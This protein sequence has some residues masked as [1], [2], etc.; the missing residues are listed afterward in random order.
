MIVWID[1]ANGVG[2]SH[3]ATE[4]AETLGC[5]NAEYMD[6]DLFWNNLLQSDSGRAISGCYP[7]CDGYFL[8]EF[9]K[10]I[11]KRHNSGKMLIIS[12]SLVHGLCE[13]DL[14]DYFKKEEVSMLHVILEAKEE[15]II[16]RIENDPIRDES[17]QNQQ[18]A[19]VSRQIQYLETQ[20]LDAV[21]IGTDDKSLTEIVNEIRMLL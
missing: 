16:S 5:E 15:T 8:G 2:K 6:S 1:G 9:R 20:Y 17:A 3:V 19:K 12:M 7:Y 13:R 18:K 21:R 14:L 11:E 4:L 10:E